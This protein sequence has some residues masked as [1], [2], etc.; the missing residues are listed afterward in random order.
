MTDQNEL[1][2]VSDER[3]L[4]ILSQNSA[5]LLTILLLLGLSVFL[6]SC[7]VFGGAL[8]QNRQTTG[9]SA[10]A[11]K[12]ADAEKDVQLIEPGKPI[13]RELADGQRHYYKIR[14]RDDQF[15]KVVV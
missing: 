15:L 13:R 1:Y 3:R 2:S 9:Q 4:R 11:G 12:G 8:G 5:P 14:L 6:I 10:D 7:Q